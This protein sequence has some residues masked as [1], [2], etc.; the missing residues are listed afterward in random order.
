MKATLTQGDF[1]FDWVKRYLEDRRIWDH[2]R[3]FHVGACNPEFRGREGSGLGDKVES[4]KKADDGHPH[5]VYQPTS[6][7]PEFLWWHGHWITIHAEPS[8]TS[9]YKDDYISM[10]TLR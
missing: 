10:L 7:Q 6:L 1:A 3:I 9:G 4:S 5:P 8:V 2:A